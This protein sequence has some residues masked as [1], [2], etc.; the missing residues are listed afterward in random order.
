MKLLRP[1]GKTNVKELY[2]GIFI[3]IGNI[4]SHG[5][6]ILVKNK[7]IIKNLKLHKKKIFHEVESKDQQNEEKA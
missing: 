3:N 2:R 5:K 7:L 6:T 4:H 1:S